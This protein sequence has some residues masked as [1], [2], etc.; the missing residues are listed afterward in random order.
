[1]I[2]IVLSSKT[3][4]PISISIYGGGGGCG[5]DVQFCKYLISLFSFHS[6]RIKKKKKE[7]KEA[8]ENKKKNQKSVKI[9]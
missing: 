8:G 1:M 4:F 9:F 2:I 7:N 6:T 3:Y 5:G